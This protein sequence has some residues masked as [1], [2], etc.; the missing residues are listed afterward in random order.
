MLVVL[1]FLCVSLCVCVN[2]FVCVRV[3][4]SP[5]APAAVVKSAERTVSG[6]GAQNGT[7]VLPTRASVATTM[8]SWF[9]KSS[10]PLSAAGTA[11]GGTS[12]TGRTLSSSRSVVGGGGWLQSRKRLVIQPFVTAVGNKPW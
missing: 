6:T 4:S 5:A 12:M 2:V 8:L 9:G 1:T 3:L 10:V 7:T 11:Q